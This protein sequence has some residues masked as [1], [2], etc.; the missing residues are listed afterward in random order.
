MARVLVTCVGSGVGQS[1]LDSLNELRQDYIIGCDMNRNVY[2][3]HFCDEFHFVPG[4]Y[5]EG[6]LD[7]LLNIAIERKVD[8]IIPGHDHELALLSKDIDKFHA[9][10]IEVL[11]SEPKVISISRD[12]YLWYE[13]FHERGCSI[14]PT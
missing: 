5:S 11:V 1:V 2:A 8:I 13:Y 10:G 14:V 12:K 7:T 6:Y 9:H 4:L 3:T